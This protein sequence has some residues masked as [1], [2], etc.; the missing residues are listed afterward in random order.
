ML[1]KLL[2]RFHD[3]KYIRWDLLRLI[4]PFLS[5]A[6]YMKRRYK[7]LTNK[8][9]ELERPSTYNEKLQWIMLNDRRPLYTLMV[10]KFAAKDYIAGIIGDKYLVPTIASWD[11]VDEI[12]F[13]SLPNQFVLKANNGVGGLVICDD[14]SKLDVAVAKKR[15]N[16]ALHMNL[17]K[18]TRE[19]PYKNVKPKLFA[20]RYLGSNLQDYRVYCFDGEPKIIYSYTNQSRED[21]NKPDLPFCDI[22]D[23]NWNPMPFHQKALPKGNIPRPDGL[24]EMIDCSRKMSKGIPHVRVDFYEI[25]GEVYIG[26]LTLFA[27]AGLSKF[28][29]EEWDDILGSWITLPEI[30][31]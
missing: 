7:L 1:K 9:L 3:P 10:D 28:Y 23:C 11:S 24:S 5:D 15:L 16:K 20:E 2:I 21:G 13:D 30:N 27:G 18:I 26:E 17:Y 29:P 4:S 31:K 12:D 22:F 19:W 25:D 14:K 6:Q 8:T